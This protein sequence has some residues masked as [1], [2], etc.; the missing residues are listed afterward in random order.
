MLCIRGKADIQDAPAHVT[1]LHRPLQVEAPPPGVIQAD[2]L[3]CGKKQYSTRTKKK[4]STFGEVK[5][6][7][8]NL[9]QVRGKLR[10]LDF[11]QFVCQCFRNN[12]NQE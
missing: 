6:T 10:G 12:F 8:Y 5:D 3:V 11:I 1:S 2:V 9:D 7:Q 4:L